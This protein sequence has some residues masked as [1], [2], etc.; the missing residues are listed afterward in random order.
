M[1]RLNFVILDINE[2]EIASPQINLPGIPPE[3]TS[4]VRVISAFAFF[5]LFSEA[6]QIEVAKII[7][8]MLEK[9]PGNVMVGIQKGMD[10]PTLR[11]VPT[12]KQGED[13]LFW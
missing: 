11:N 12:E 10:V 13:V 7:W 5:H 4:K 8:N 3:T 9:E 1:S 6:R 2:V